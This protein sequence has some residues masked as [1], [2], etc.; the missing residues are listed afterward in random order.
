M[1]T[2]SQVKKLFSADLTKMLAQGFQQL[3]PLYHWLM[4]VEAMKQVDPA[5]L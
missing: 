2:D 5:D 4:Q 3:E 1:A